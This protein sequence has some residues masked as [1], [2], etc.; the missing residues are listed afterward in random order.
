MV[1]MLFVLCSRVIRK[2]RT[3]GKE[4][5]FFKECTVLSRLCLLSS[6]SF[7]FQVARRAHQVMEDLQITVYKKTVTTT[8]TTSTTTM[9]TFTKISMRQR[10]CAEVLKY[11]IKTREQVSIVFPIFTLFYGGRVSVC[12]T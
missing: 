12:L 6:F 2:G 7:F 9:K 3:V 10:C 8:A 1:Q 11:G 4:T 5:D